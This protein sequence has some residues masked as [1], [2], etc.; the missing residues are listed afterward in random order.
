MTEGT[1]D[2]SYV[3]GKQDLFAIVIALRYL[4]GNDEFKMF[5]KSLKL[6]I[7]RI[8]KECPHISESQLYAYMG[9]PSNWENITRFRK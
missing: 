2:G 7:N 4:L 3:L 9:F 1:E 6:L 5:K 8:H